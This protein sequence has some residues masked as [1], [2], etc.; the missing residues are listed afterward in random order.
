MGNQIEFKLFLY[1]S[2]PVV[3]EVQI[4]IFFLFLSP[5]FS[6]SLIPPYYINFLDYAIIYVF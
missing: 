5:C 3:I 4:Y 1:E 2:F 6:L